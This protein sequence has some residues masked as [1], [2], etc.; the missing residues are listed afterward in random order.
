MPGD[1]GAP[2]FGAKPRSGWWLDQI[3][4]MLR[5]VASAFACWSSVWYVMK[6]YVPPAVTALDPTWFESKTMTCDVVPRGTAYTSLY[7][8]PE[9]T[10]PS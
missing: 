1:G 7:A 8:P 6:F 9:R 4:K 3:L 2:A 5:L 10:P